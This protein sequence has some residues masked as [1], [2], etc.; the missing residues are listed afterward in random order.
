MPPHRAFHRAGL[1]GHSGS[2]Q[3]LSRRHQ[4]LVPRWG[5]GLRRHMCRPHDYA[6]CLGTAAGNHRRGLPLS[7]RSGSGLGRRLMLPDVDLPEAPSRTRFNCVVRTRRAPVRRSLSSRPN[8]PPRHRRAAPTEHHRLY[9]RYDAER[10]RYRTVRHRR[11]PQRSQQR[12]YVLSTG[13]GRTG[14]RA[15]MPRLPPRPTAAANRDA[16]TAD[17]IRSGPR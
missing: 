15:R 16:S 9:G 2:A 12:G 10:F 13:G 6:A 14:R 17:S 5:F 8:M 11:D 4:R 3:R 1:T 7:S